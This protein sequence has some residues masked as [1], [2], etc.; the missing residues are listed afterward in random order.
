MS[1]GFSHTVRKVSPKRAVKQWLHIE[2]PEELYK[3]TV[4]WSGIWP[5]YQDFKAILLGSQI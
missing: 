1:R 5:R 3:A 4:N 2:S